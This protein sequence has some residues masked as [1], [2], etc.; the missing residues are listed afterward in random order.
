M[1]RETDGAP[2][3]DQLRRSVV[4]SLMRDEAVR[5]K[6]YLDC[7]SKPWRECTCATKGKLTI[8]VGQNLDDLGLN[9]DEIM[10]LLDNRIDESVADCVQVFPWFASLDLVRQGVIVQMRFNLGLA[11][12]LGFHNTLAAIGRG[13]YKAAA[14]GMEASLWAKQVGDRAKRLARAMRTGKAF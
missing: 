12:L 4:P 1:S 14:D 6:P 5:K 3:L 10:F 7:C 2:S 11:K 13:D 8:G 9:D